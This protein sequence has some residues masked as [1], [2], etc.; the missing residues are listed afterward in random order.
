MPSTGFDN[1]PAPFTQLLLLTLALIAGWAIHLIVFKLLK[2][3]NKRKPTVFLASLITHLSKPAR[4]ALPL[5]LVL[6]VLGGGMFSGQAYMALAKIGQVFFIM[7]LAWVFIKCEDIFEDVIR[8]A[9]D[10][11]KS[12]NIRERT[13]HT[14][15]NYIRKLM[16]LVVVIIAAGLILMNFESVRKIGSTLLTSAGVAGIIIGMAAQ[17]SIK[18]LL[19]GLQIAFTQPIRYDDVVIVENEWGWIEDITLTYV[20]VRIWDLRRLV[21]PLNY[22]IEHPFQN[23]TKTNADI[24]GTVFLHADY[25]LPLEPVREE[26][27]RFVATR[28]EWDK[29]VVGLQVTNATDKGIE[30]RALV[31]AADSGKA[32][33]LRCALREHLITF[34][35]K[36]Y[37]Q[38]LI[39]I[40]V[41][42][43]PA[44]PIGVS[45][46]KVS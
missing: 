29:K 38:C 39:K 23:W 22:F 41:E 45:A 37:P 42:N 20:V 46:Q 36:N 17:N 44:N 19:A 43:S 26:L 4:Y 32:W 18:N 16:I 5:L 2:Q 12:N 30:L 21:L 24:L 35:Q 28:E 13:I 33:N 10:L 25:T 3:I 40:R 8:D 9:F 1:L 27:K 31:S 7:T 11:T 15:M 6:I 14:Q 34:I